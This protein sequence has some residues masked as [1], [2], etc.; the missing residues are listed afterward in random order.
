MFPELGRKLGFQ[1]MGHA[2]LRSILHLDLE[3][4]GLTPACPLQKQK[5]CRTYKINFQL[6]L[7][8]TRPRLAQTEGLLIWVDFP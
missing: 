1:Y 7:N 6:E 2:R 5:A 8:S 4:L 3:R